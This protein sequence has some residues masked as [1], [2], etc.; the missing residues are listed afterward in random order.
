MA[1]YIW[2]CKVSWHRTLPRRWRQQMSFHGVPIPPQTRDEGNHNDRIVLCDLVP[3]H[4]WTIL[5]SRCQLCCRTLDDHVEFW[6]RICPPQ[7][8]IWVLGFLSSFWYTSEISIYQKKVFLYNKLTLRTF[9][10]PFEVTYRGTRKWSKIIL[11]LF[12]RNSFW[13]VCKTFP[14]NRRMSL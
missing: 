3:C 6:L 7:R 9:W 1:S 5:A 14:V 11:N 10:W 4:S 8:A 12:H 2:Q 13:L